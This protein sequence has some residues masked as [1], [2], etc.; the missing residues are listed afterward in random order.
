MGLNDLVCGSTR[1]CTTREVGC[2]VEVQ[3]H[4]W[5]KSALAGGQLSA[6]HS[7]QL[8]TLTYLHLPFPGKELSAIAYWIGLSVDSRIS[9]HWV[10]TSTDLEVSKERNIVYPCL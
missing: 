9:G 7:S 1:V 10:N 5:L 3:H 2:G 4:L 8:L 6:S